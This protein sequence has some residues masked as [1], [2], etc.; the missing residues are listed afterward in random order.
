MCL[1]FYAMTRRA[2]YSSRIGQ[3][4]EGSNYTLSILKRL[5]LAIYKDFIIQERF[6]ELLGKG[7][8]D[9]PES[10]GLAGPDVEM[11]FMRKLRKESLW[12][13]P[14]RLEHY[15]EADLFDVIE[16]LHDYVSVGTEG[17]MHSY[18]GCGM[19]YS[20]FDRSSG[21]SEFR[22]AINDI[23]ADYSTGYELSS[24]GEIIHLPEAGFEHL[25]QAPIPHPDYRNVGSLIDA[26]VLKY[27]RR[28]STIEDRRSAVLDLIHVLEFLRPQVK[29]YFATKDEADLFNIANNFGLRHHN[30]RQRNDYDPNIWT[31]WMFYFYLATA[32]TAV[33]LIERGRSKPTS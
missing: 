29:E 9:D 7:C 3:N 2:Y 1:L 10:Y 14:D 30:D 13:I 28:A 17:W 8:V 33:R 26:A 15:S 16:L 11:F 22:T 27:R 31:S 18:A 21:Q 6:Q 24:Q 32:H 4:P 19:H 23:L 5:F 12:P 20:R 25:S